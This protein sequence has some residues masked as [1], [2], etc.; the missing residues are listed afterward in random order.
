VWLPD[1][2][3]TG[4]LVFVRRFADGATLT[5]IDTAEAFVVFR[6]VSDPP[7]IGSRVRILPST[8]E[9]WKFAESVHP[10]GL[11]IELRFDDEQGATA[12]TAWIEQ[13]RT[14]VRMLDAALAV[15]RDQLVARRAQLGACSEPGS[16]EELWHEQVSSIR[17]WVMIETDYTADEHNEIRRARAK[18]ARSADQ[19]ERK[20]LEAR[21]KRFTERGNAEI[22]R[23]REERWP[24][25]REAALAEIRKY[26]EYRT[27]VVRLEDALQQLRALGERGTNAAAM[28][29]RIEAASFRVSGTSF[30]PERLAET[31]YAE[32]LLRTIELLDAAVPQRAQLAAARFSAYRASTGRPPAT[33]PRA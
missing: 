31:G 18:G 22:A 12:D 28:L 9:N 8:L 19:V 13:L 7:P 32:E 26:D 16:L 10:L 30:D 4:I 14:G 3:Y 20:I 33:P 6:G 27:E 5:G 25:M 2:I 23:F 1:A 29:D 15:R 24:A 17:D 21:R 11:G